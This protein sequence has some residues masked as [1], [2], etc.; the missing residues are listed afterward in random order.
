MGLNLY[1]AFVDAGLPAPAMDL[2]APVGGPED[3]PG[4]Q[5]VVEAFRSL[6]P[7]IE[8]FGIAT[9]EEVDLDTLSD[10]LRNEVVATKRAFMLPPH[11]TAWAVAPE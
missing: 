10:R 6:V 4:Y 11:V 2:A 1:G 3:W 7:L 9:A 5:F 8:E